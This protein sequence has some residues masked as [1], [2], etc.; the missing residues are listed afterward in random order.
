MSFESRARNQCTLIVHLIEI[1][2]NQLNQS[3]VSFGFSYV[4]SMY[5][6]AYVLYA[7]K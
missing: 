5:A 6:I 7:E 3:N 2:P 1:R 4:N